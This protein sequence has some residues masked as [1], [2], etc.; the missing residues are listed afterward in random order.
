MLTVLFIGFFTML[1]IGVPIAFAMAGSATL[2]LLLEG[3]VPLLLVVQRTYAGGDSFALMAI[4]FFIIAG[5]IMT[6]SRMT[7]RLVE[8]CNALLSHLRSGLAGVTVAACVVFAGISGSGSADTAAIGSVLTPQLIAKGYPRG[9]AAA[10]VSTAGALGPI[11]PPSLLMIIYAAIAEQSVGQLFLAGILPGVMIGVGLM[12]VIHV[13]NT[14]RGWEAPSG[15]RISPARVGRALQAA[16]LPLGTPVVIV[17]GIVGGIFTATEA[18]VVA[19]VYA[20]LVAYFYS[21]IT[22]SALRQA[23]IQSGLLSSL[24]LFIISM[25]AVFGW[26]LARQDFPTTVADAV[27]SI[28]DGNQLLGAA[29]VIAMVLALGFFIEVLALMII[30]VPILAPV[31]PALGF[32]PIHWGL[33]MVMSMNVGGIT[34]PVGTNMF[35]SASIAKCSLVEISIYSIPMVAVHAIVVFLMLLMPDIALWIPR[36]VFG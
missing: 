15:E 20:L 19:A 1:V 18:G 32:D 23:L 3:Q 14:R 34:P 16:L 11:I 31:G 4:P 8:L 10:I 33:L 21:G 30:F 17:G 25:A 36:A 7:D 6:A 2:A 29:L 35:I 26:I 22:W 27:L 5:E 12:G 13:W 9:F 28:S 24:S